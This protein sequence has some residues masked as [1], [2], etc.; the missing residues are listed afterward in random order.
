[1]CIIKN[2]RFM[3]FNWLN[4]DVTLYEYT[5]WFFTNHISNSAS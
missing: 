3:H 2:G 4:S 5:D 1:M